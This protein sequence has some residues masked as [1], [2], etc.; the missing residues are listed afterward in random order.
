[1]ESDESHDSGLSKG[2][3]KYK[4]GKW[5]QVSLTVNRK[6]L[7]HS[8]PSHIP[9]SNCKKHHTKYTNEHRNLQI[10]YGVKELK[11]KPD[12]NK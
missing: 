7:L 5:N 6:Y 12:E 11:Y 2:V 9:H 3:V 10:Q 8:L 1:M 4:N